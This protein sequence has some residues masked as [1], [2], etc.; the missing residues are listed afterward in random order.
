MLVLSQPEFVDFR[1]QLQ[2]GSTLP[3]S[4]RTGW[5][6]QGNERDRAERGLII[7]THGSPGEGSDASAGCQ[8]PNTDPASPT[9][10]R[11]GTKTH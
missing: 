10:A 6:A 9:L 3:N 2:S 1:Q 11:E 7:P 4:Q 5:Y 8:C